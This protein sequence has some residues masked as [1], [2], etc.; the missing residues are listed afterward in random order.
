[1]ISVQGESCE[2]KDLRRIGTRGFAEF[3][4]VAEPIVFSLYKLTNDLDACQAS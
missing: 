1:M 2:Q 4:E 3:V